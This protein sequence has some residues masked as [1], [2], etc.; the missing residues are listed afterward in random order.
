[1]PVGSAPSA[2]R[3][4][5]A[6]AYG[7]A[8][9]VAD[10]LRGEG[11]RVLRTIGSDAPLPL[12]RAAG[13]APVRLA[14][15]PVAGTPR[16]DALLGPA[17]ARRRAHLLAERLLDPGLIDPVLFTRADAEQA[18]VFS[19]L[20]ENARLGAPTGMAVTLLDLLHIDRPSSRAYNAA[21]LAQLRD[22]LQTQGGTSF[23]EAD[24]AREAEAADAVNAL[25]RE[26]DRLRPRL[27][28]TDM[29]RS[30]GC[31][32]ILPPEEL[33][34]LLRGLR[35]E[36]A[37]LPEASGTATLCAGSPH[38]TDLHYAAIEREGLRIVGEVHDWGIARALRPTPRSL[39]EWAD[40]AYTI[41]AAAARS[42]VLAQ[43]A[44]AA[45]RERKVERI[46]HLTLDGDEA[47]PW[48]VAALHR[49]LNGPEHDGAPAE[50]AALKCPLDDTV[51]LVKALRKDEAAPETAI[52]KPAAPASAA[53]S[54]PAPRTRSRKVL[55]ASA[56]SGD[57][58]RDWF[59]SVRAQVV[60]GAPFAMVNANAPQEILRALGVPF[61][62]NQWWASIVAAKQQSG[63]YRALLRSRHYPTDA[64]AYSAQGVAAALDRDAEQ[65]P[66]S[67][68]P[69]PDFVQAIA[70]S[71][72]T[73]AI[74]EA[75]A[76]ESGAAAF[77]YERTVDPRW[78]IE[79]RWW[80]AL[81]DRWQEVLEPERLDLLVAEL[82][83]VIAEVE[84]ATGQRF[85]EN[86]FVEVMNLVNEQEEYY[87]MTRDLIARTVPAPIGVVDSM[88]ATM[89]PQW[90]RGT[91]WGRDAA[92]ALYEEVSERAAAGLGAIADEKV[93]LMWVGR[94][95]WSN[96]AFYQKW[97]DSHGAV[98]VWSMYLAL[99]ADGYIR[100]FD[101]EGGT[102]DSP[103][104]PLRALA[105]RFLT[106]GDELRMPSWAAPWHVHEA[107]TH[108]IDGAVALDDADPFV[109]RAL[110][111][112]GIPVL[113]LGV[114]N[115]ALDRADAD[116]LEARIAAFIE[117][118]CAQMAQDRRRTAA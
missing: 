84:S 6:A 115:Y 62:V 37:A 81:P 103:R 26:L 109:L 78:A 22:W 94:G 36:A 77:V 65:A 80:E 27:S 61:V 97:E 91:E 88:P 30:I 28:G 4:A 2:I 8:D 89:V 117:G 25:L 34:P 55:K 93:R 9:T 48:T 68:L 96:T 110:V 15:R 56:S 40:P 104:S 101:A 53:T 116:D 52:P 45:V 102:H 111:A 72:A 66:W 13:F 107:Q 113:E 114:D 69:R 47:A 18:Q 112:A 86:R 118:P 19:A 95:L 74:F 42:E 20:R 108:G 79:T 17:A 3:A 24:L 92:R 29:L 32:A 35:D 10:R 51:P 46:L 87:R 57:Y 31:A 41:P 76:Y 58:Q 54:A 1:V 71:D 82:R 23:T 105:A 100:R 50:I 7:D 106:M 63:R 75:W 90:H 85:D 99:A 38:E 64:E 11:R 43:E 67:G 14:P 60:S 44:Q 33:I 16:A 83:Q 98:F 73:P 5:I 70:S 39:A 12:L 49:A 59:A 21:R